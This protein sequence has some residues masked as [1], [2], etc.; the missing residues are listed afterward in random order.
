MPGK[1]RTIAF[2]L[3]QF[4]TIPENDAW[5]GKGFTDWT[6][7]RAARGIFRGHEHP[8]A[9]ADDRH[10]DLTDAKELRHQ[11]EQASQYG[12][13]AFC[14]YFYWFDGH[15]LLERPLDLYKDM[16]DALPFCVSWANENWTRRWDGNDREVLIAQNYTPDTPA[17]V[18]QSLR[19]YFLAPHY[20]KLD[21]RPVLLVHRTDLL[22]QPREYAAVWNRLA[23][24]DGFPGL[25]LVAAETRAGIDPR[26]W[27][28]DAVAEFPPVTRNV[29]RNAVL[30]PPADLHRDFSGRLMSYAKV[31]RSSLRRP[32]P[33]FTRYRGVMP[34]WDNTARRA[35]ASTIYLGHSPE[36][37]ERWLAGAIQKETANRGDQGF[38]FINAWNEW[39]EGAYLQPDKTHG[40]RYL[41]ATAR[42]VGMEF[43]PSAF[44]EQPRVADHG[45]S[46]RIHRMHVRSLINAA[47]SSG[48]GIARHAR[49]KLSRTMRR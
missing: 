41:E 15:R 1:P 21:G 30:L 14:M 44:D 13:N 31:A 5:W 34:A 2:F 27:D 17:A 10:Y 28:F 35:T 23:F 24:D 47:G 42:A 9:P 39:A 38:V 32:E 6:N 25:H 46:W 43:Q 33:N 3:P 40:T 7:T 36:R 19:E 45:K 48:L 29:L 18:Y 4:H 26:S 11:A 49:A 16:H 8:K 22:P 37:Y 20:L 12:I